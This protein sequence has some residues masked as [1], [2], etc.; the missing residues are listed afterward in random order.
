MKFSEIKNMSVKELEEKL[1]EIRKDLI[2]ENAQVA[3]G[4]TP[5]NPGKLRNQKKMVAKIKT[6]MT[7]KG[8]TKA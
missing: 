8:V 3:I 4:T 6:A 7:M 5:K 2:K 1:Q